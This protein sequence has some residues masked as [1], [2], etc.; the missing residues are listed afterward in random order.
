MFNQ[1]FAEILCELPPLQ[2]ADLPL[3]YPG[4]MIH[5][6]FHDLLNEL[7]M[8]V[9]RKWRKQNRKRKSRNRLLCGPRAG[10][11]G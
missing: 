10:E 4:F 5:N 1:F 2:A 11:E 8:A 3:P 9:V 7:H 6:H